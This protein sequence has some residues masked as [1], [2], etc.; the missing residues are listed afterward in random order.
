MF[1]VNWTRGVLLHPLPF[2]ILFLFFQH[3]PESA[4]AYAKT[5]GSFFFIPMFFGKNPL[6][7]LR[8][9]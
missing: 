6:Y 3:S 8:R 9:R 5:F 4:S 1:P 2:V 7:D